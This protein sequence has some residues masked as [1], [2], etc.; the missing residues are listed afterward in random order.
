MHL[1]YDSVL[2]A[3][4]HFA[5]QIRYGASDLSFAQ[6]WRNLPKQKGANNTNHKNKSFVGVSLGG[7]SVVCPFGGKAWGRIHLFYG[8]V[9]TVSDTYY[10][11]S[12]RMITT[13]PLAV[14]TTASLIVTTTAPLVVTTNRPVCDH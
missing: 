2:L 4:C 9:L 12:P 8:S 10:K 3:T 1:F 14:D 13:M 7:I 6:C 5:H 11:R